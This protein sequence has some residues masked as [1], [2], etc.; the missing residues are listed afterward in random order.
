VGGCGGG[1]RSCMWT[2]GGRGGRARGREGVRVRVAFL[3]AG[4]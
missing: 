4:G 2:R 3:R 1:G